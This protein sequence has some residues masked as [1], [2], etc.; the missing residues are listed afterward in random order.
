MFIPLLD[1]LDLENIVV[2]ADAAHTQRSN[3]LW[4]RDQ[5]AHC[6]AVVKGNHPGLLKQLRKLPWADIARTTRTAP[7]AGAGSRSD[8]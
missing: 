2:T 6:I 8:T 5:G 7:G 3:G 1:G 4:L